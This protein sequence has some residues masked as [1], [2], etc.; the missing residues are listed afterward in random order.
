MAEYD[1]IIIGTGPAGLTAGL[2]A[3]R[4]NLKTLAIGESLGGQM[5]LAHVVE[6]YPGMDPINGLVLAEKMKMQAEKA[7]CEIKVGTV[8]RS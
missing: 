6:N 7:G 8:Q 4:R 1:I 5:S 2:Y 3:A